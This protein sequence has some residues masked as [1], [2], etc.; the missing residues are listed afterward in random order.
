VPYIYTNEKEK[1]WVYG[2]TFIGKVG[3]PGS[4][5]VL[6]GN[7]R[8]SLNF[9]ISVLTGMPWD[10]PTKTGQKLLYV[11]CRWMDPDFNLSTSDVVRVSG[12]LTKVEKDLGLLTNKC[13]VL[14]RFVKKAQLK[15]SMEDPRVV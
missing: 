3:T 14:A 6:H 8:T 9:S 5:L 1:S 11:R 10:N 2:T 12:M 13:E 7:G 15:T 4:K